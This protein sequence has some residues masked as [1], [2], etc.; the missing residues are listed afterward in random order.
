MNA[1]LH[2]RQLLT[3]VETPL[4]MNQDLI[5]T[6]LDPAEACSH[7][8]PTVLMLTVICVCSVPEVNTSKGGEKNFTIMLT[9]LEFPCCHEL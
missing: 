5:Y 6:L 8:T 1:Y 4:L 3:L 9:R 7:P 2:V